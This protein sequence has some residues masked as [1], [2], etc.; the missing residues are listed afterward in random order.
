M[1]GVAGP[2]PRKERGRGSKDGT[3]RSLEEGWHPAQR[4][5]VQE[6]PNVWDG[7][8]VLL[9]RLYWLAV[10]AVKALE[11]VRRMAGR[12]RGTNGYDRSAIVE[13]AVFELLRA[14][15]ADPVVLVRLRQYQETRLSEPRIRAQEFEELAR[16]AGADLSKIVRENANPGGRRKS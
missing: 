16:A 2:L 13:F 7:R 15:K 4:Y 11:A 12:V 9:N 6:M 3:G 5:A 1:K 8:L 10:P 14:A